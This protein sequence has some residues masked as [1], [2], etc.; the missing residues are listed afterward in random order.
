MALLTLYHHGECERCRRI[1]RVNKAFDWLGRLTI[2]T[3]ESPIGPMKMGEIAV[4]DQGSGQ[5]LQGVAAVRKVFK[6]IP[7][8]WLVLPLLYVPFIARKI[9]RDTRGC[10]DGSCAVRSNP[11]EERQVT[12]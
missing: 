11:I 7:A 8:Y 3:A 6:Q 4:V 12:S 5:V 9:D 1:A 2:S 10:E